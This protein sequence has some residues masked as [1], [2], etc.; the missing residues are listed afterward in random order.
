[1]H[2]LRF[3]HYHRR[4]IGTAV[5]TVITMT[6][7]LSAYGGV[8]LDGTLGPAG[9]LPG[10]DYQIGA[11][12]GRQVGGNLFHSFGQFSINTGESATFSG[13]NSVSNIIG[14][15]AG[16]N[17]SFIDGTLRL[18]IPGANLYLLNPAGVLF[19]E[20]AQLDVPGSVH[21]SMADYLRLSDGG[22]FDARMPANSVLTVA[23]V[24]AFGFLGDTPGRI[25]VDGAFL[26]VPEG[27]TLS[28][29]GGDMTLTDATLYAPAGRI[30]L[31]AVGSAGDVAPTDTD[32]VMNGFGRLGAITVERATV[33]RPKI[34]DSELGDVDTSGT[35]GGAIFIRAGQFVGQDRS[36]I[37]SNTT[38]DRDGREINVDVDC[39]LLNDGAQITTT[40]FGAG[41]GGDINVTA[42]EDIII[43]SGFVDPNAA[44]RWNRF[45]PSALTANAASDDSQ[46]GNITLLTRR[47]SLTRGGSIGSNGL[48]DA[49]GLASCGNII[50]TATE[51]IYMDANHPD[52]LADGSPS[53]VSTIAPRYAG[54]IQ[55]STARLTLASSGSIGT[56][57]WGDGSGRA[58][59]IDITASEAVVIDSAAAGLYADAYGSEGSMNAG[60]ITL[61]TGRLSL[62]R[63]AQITSGIYGL[64]NG[65]DIKI[66]AREAMT[67]AGEGYS[68]NRA[69]GGLGFFSGV[70]TSSCDT[71]SG[72][73]G[74]ITVTTPNLLIAASQGVDWS[75]IGETAA[76]AKGT[77]IGATA[78]SASG[79]RITINAD[80]LKLLDGA[81]INTSV[82][83]DPTS[84][85]GNITI[86]GINVVAL[87][88][89]K[90][91]AQ[92]N[93]GRG[94]NITLNTEVFLHDAPSAA[95][96]LNASSQ[97][98]GNDGTVR[99][100][101]PTTDLSGSLLGLNLS[102][103]D[104]A[105][106]LTD[107]CAEGDRDTRSRFTVQGRG[108]L[109]PSPDE[110]VTAA[111][112]GC[113]PERP[114]AATPSAR[115]PADLP[116]HPVPGFG[117]R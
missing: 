97:V 35:G 55:I 68:S 45:Q 7:A 116:G 11:D 24:E 44:M 90:I 9:T 39:L 65:G 8:T 81:Q 96:V 107:R 37:Q 33:E 87:N 56:F 3:P 54:N 57:T 74:N 82:F 99:N 112:G 94:G 71:C 49:D 66:I 6:V 115:P 91:T 59:N 102:Y 48:S 21:V 72:N 31:A 58:G 19:G 70:F 32:L 93:Q 14:R 78:G 46:A 20:H 51:S 63:G 12:L 22:R 64:G 23:P 36:L 77:G 30:N 29:I 98:Q 106:Q 67:I 28:L 105:G 34:D 86:N 1:M 13:P 15:V 40:S 38:G 117:D 62:T 101:A 108:A 4:L 25:T 53:S 2:A 104:V 85:G 41:R 89:S 79:G 84:Q 43:D 103:L 52:Y 80:H 83:G 113:H 100:N 111:V 75:G 73:A 42:S 60:N 18:T 109:P 114:T 16:G 50:I 76:D 88:G 92:A 61:V 5:G 110:P 10:P 69:S 27:Q 47:L 17:A 95:D 26:Q